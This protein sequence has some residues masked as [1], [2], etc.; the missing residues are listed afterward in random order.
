MEII[1]KPGIYD[2]LPMNFYHDDCCDGP[3]ISGSGLHKIESL[4]PA[5]YW[6]HSPLNPNRVEEEERSEVLDIGRAAHQWHLG[7]ADFAKEFIISP[8]DD[9]RKLDARGWRDTQ[10]AKG[11]TPIKEAQLAGIKGM[12]DA[13]RRHDIASAAFVGGKPEQSVIWQDKETGVW[14]KSR[15]DFLPDTPRFIPNYKTCTSAHPDALRAQIYTYGYYISAVLCLEGLEVVTGKRP[16]AY[17]FIFQEKKAPYLI[18]LATLD[19]D[20]I[21]WG[22]RQVRR[23]IRIFADCLSSGKWPSYA[24]DVIEVGL[25][26]WAE[27]QLNVRSEAGDFADLLAGHQWKHEEVYAKP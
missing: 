2:D 23:A 20:A 8:Y 18:T 26:R 15:P 17:Y 16:D 19:G 3:S 1:E 24:P 12:G 14:L 5:A 22:Q 4:C 27:Y 10:I 21:G 25:P 9:Y 11:M 6:A 7:E 13:L